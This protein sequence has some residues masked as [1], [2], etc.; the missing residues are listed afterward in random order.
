[1][2]EVALSPNA[3]L[4]VPATALM[5]MPVPNAPDVSAP[6]KL[7]AADAATVAFAGVIVLV[8]LL[9]SKIDPGTVTAPPR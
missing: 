2:F 9:S 7:I 6:F 1:M 5:T 8:M 3:F 4:A